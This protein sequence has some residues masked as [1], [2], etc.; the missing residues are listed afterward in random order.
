[1][2]HYVYSSDSIW[3]VQLFNRVRDGLAES[4]KSLIPELE[5][6]DNDKKG[7]LFVSDTQYEDMELDWADPTAVA[8]ALVLGSGTVTTEENTSSVFSGA[9]TDIIED[10]CSDYDEKAVEIIN[11]KGE[12]IT[13]PS[14]ANNIAAI[15]NAAE[16]GPYYIIEDG[17]QKECYD[18]VIYGYVT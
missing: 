10:Y 16:G 3:N 18:V 6:D 13:R 4:Y 8:E 11:E 2:L 1:M 15:S 5:K 7:F 12:T 17:I 14:G 9:Y